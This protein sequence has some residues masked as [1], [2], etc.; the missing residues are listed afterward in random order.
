MLRAASRN[1]AKVVFTST[2]GALYG[3]RATFPTPEDARPA[4]ISPYGASKWS[5]E[6]YVV[7]WARQPGLHTPCVGSAMSMARARARTVKLALSRSS[8]T[9]SRPG[10]APTMYGF[11]NATRTMS[12]FTMWPEPCSLPWGP[13][14]HLQ[15]LQWSRNEGLADLGDAARCRKDDVDRRLGSTAGR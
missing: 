3:N 10:E 11:G 8:A 7:T 14:G 15:H 1:Q 9:T 13:A 6:A 4:P 12:M 5:G 2:G